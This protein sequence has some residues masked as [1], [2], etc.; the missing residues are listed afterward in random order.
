MRGEEGGFQGPAIVTW[1]H[2]Q[3]Q[4][5]KERKGTQEYGKIRTLSQK[6]DGII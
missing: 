2:S 3:T 4:S 6:I 5:K 1:L